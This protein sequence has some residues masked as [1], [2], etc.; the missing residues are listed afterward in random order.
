M[1]SLLIPHAR[2]ALRATSFAALRHPLAACSLRPLSSAASPTDIVT[3]WKATVLSKPVLVERDTIRPQTLQQLAMTLDKA[4]P[5]LSSSATS[6]AK[7]SKAGALLP[8]NW[9]HVYFPPMI[10]EQ[11]LGQDGYEMTHAPPAPFLARM[12]AGGGVQQNPANPLRVGQ[13]MV[14]QTK[15]TGV[16][17]KQSRTGDT[18]VFVTLEKLVENEAGWALT[19]TRTLVY[20]EKDEKSVHAPKPKIVKPRK[21]ADFSMQVFPT[22]ITLFRYSALTFN[23]HRIHFDH[24]YAN[25]VEKYP[26]CL[27]HGPLTSTLMLENLR[28]RLKPG[29]IV[30]NFRYRALSPLFVNQPIKICAKNTAVVPT[31]DA[32]VVESYEVWVE[33]PEGGLAMSGT[34]EVV[35]A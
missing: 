3:D 32:D 2:L 5:D 27:V 16:D 35:K 7:L 34:V 23:S 30:K 15:C 26:G 25:Q 33:N 19:D 18:M 6:I 28:L 4:T 20:M 29:L 1:A 12:W 14:M 9:H 22:A 10:G 24:E 31:M 21:Q 13:Q 8:V 11:D 17:I